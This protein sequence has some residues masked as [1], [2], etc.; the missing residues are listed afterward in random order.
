MKFKF[1]IY[2]LQ[3]T[4]IDRNMFCKGKVVVDFLRIAELLITL[5]VCHYSTVTF[6]VI[7]TQGHAVVDF[8]STINRSETV[9]GIT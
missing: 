3:L 8:F 7:L 5:I 1:V 9:T 6:L 4:M 2:H